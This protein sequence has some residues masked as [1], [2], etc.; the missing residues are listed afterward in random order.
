MEG[1]LGHLLEAAC[2]LSWSHY[3]FFVT[4]A[5]FRMT[6]YD[7]G[8]ALSFGTTDSMT[9]ESVYPVFTPMLGILD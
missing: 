1:L 5:A 9:A 3:I 4:A 2:P 6:L 7:C 8:S